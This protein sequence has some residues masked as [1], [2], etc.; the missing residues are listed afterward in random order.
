MNIEITRRESNADWNAEDGFTGEEQHT[1]YGVTPDG[2][3]WVRMYY[4][5]AGDDVVTEEV[6]GWTKVAK[7]R[8][9]MLAPDTV[10]T[11]DLPF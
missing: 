1:E 7:R 5:M 9:T 8:P 10:E 11:F 6:H 4:T 2:Q 3:L